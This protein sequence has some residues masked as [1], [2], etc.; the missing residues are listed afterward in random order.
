MKRTFSKLIALSVFS[1]LLAAP[2]IASAV[3]FRLHN[4]P[5]G[6]QNP[7][8]Y[9]LRLDGLF[10][11]VDD[12]Y[13]FDFDYSA[14]GFESEVFLEYNGS[15]I[16]I[17]GSAFGGEDIGNT[18][19]YGLNQGIYNIDFTYTANIIGDV[20]SGL[21]VTAYNYAANTGTVTYDESF[22]AGVFTDIADSVFYLQDQD[23]GNFSFKFNNTD[24][25][26]LPGADDDTFVGWGWVNHS[27]VGGTS[28]YGHVYSSDWL[29]TAT[30]VPD[31]GTTAV[32][33]LIGLVG[34]ESER[35]RMQ[36][37]TA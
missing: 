13:T 27:T 14:S 16:R 7:P 23:D 32:L 25:H 36:K 5:D 33:I 15:T 22:S 19:A 1:G 12:E 11:D 31:M 10:G 9:G 6:N 21:T 28:S 20:V 4:H 29:F 3:T 17:Y 35:R 30:Q 24:D 26:R 34:L 8:P 18:G 37:R 2:S